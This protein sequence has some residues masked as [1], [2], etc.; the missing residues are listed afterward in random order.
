VEADNYLTGRL[1]F[2][3]LTSIDRILKLGRILLIALVMDKSKMKEKIEE[4]CLL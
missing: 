4:Y 1:I 3:F 2:C